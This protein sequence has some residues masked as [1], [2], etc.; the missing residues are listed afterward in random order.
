MSIQK[1]SK[2]ELSLE[3]II[4]TFVTF[5]KIIVK[6][7]GIWTLNTKHGGIPLTQLVYRDFGSINKT[8]S[9]SVCLKKKGL[10][11]LEGVK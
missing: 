8:D 1:H 11:C 2:R 10:L 7:F 6:V 4:F 9:K 5:N 3:A